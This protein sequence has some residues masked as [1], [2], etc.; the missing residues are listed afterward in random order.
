MTYLIKQL[1]Q[2]RDRV[3][4]EKTTLEK[5]MGSF[6]PIGDALVPHLEAQLKNVQAKEKENEIIIG[7]QQN[8][9]EGESHP[10]SAQTVDRCKIE[11]INTMVD[12]FDNIIQKNYCLYANYEDFSFAQTRNKKQLEQQFWDFVRRN[13]SGEF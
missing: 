1:N 7:Q 10:A 4:L 12:D 6:Y 8:P 5:L 13:F 3:Q 2:N 11:A 9:S